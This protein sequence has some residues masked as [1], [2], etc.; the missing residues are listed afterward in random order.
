MH[1]VTLK[2]F[3]KMCLTLPDGRP[4][5]IALAAVGR[6]QVRLGVT[7]D[8]DIRVVRQELLPPPAAV[9][10]PHYEPEDDPE[11]EPGALPPPPWEEGPVPDPL[12]PPEPGDP[13]GYNPPP[14][15][16]ALEA[17]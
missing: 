10:K 16:A 3:E 4:V 5:V 14:A 12:Q 15:D 13:P 17:S 2:T 1:L 11:S 9:E 8:R 7:C 6:G